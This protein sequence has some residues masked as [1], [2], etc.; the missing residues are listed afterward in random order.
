MKKEILERAKELESDIEQ[1]ESALSYY[2]KGKWRHWGINDDARSFHFE[3]CMNWSH[4]DA[5]MQDLPT[6]LNKPLME[7]IEKELERCKQELK[8]LGNEQEEFVTG[9]IDTDA[10]IAELESR[11]YVV[12]EERLR[13]Q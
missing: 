6:W 2:K 10:L 9:N 13:I 12:K 11:G 4:R 7:V 1:M 8:T 3:F 5:D